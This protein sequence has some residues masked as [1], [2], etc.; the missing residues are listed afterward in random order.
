ME[1]TGDPAGV[2]A[3]KEM[4]AADKGFVKFILNEARSNFD[5]TARFTAKDGK[6]KAVASLIGKLPVKGK[7]AMIIPVR[8][9]ML[10]RGVRNLKAIH[11]SRVSDMNMLD[12][13]RADY[14]LTTPEA[15]ERIEK[16][17]GKAK[18]A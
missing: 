13:L 15:V 1:L 4:H 18:K 6:T 3:L 11:L 17:Y 14:V 5:F 12:V 10:S 7:L 16:L 2:A 9:E 8:D